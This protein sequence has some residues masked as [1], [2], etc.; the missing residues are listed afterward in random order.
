MCVGK[1]KKQDLSDTWKV[2]RVFEP[3]MSADQ[4]GAL[5]SGWQQAIRTITQKH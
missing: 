4:R 1:W 2:D 3:I 5:R